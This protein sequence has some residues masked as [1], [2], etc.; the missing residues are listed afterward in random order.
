MH[1]KIRRVHLVLAVRVERNQRDEFAEFR[2][3]RHERE[4]HL[5]GDL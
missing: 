3:I 4:L 1:R 2:V 5:H